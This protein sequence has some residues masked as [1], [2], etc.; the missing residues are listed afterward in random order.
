MWSR[1]ASSVPKGWLRLGGSSR[2]I[3]SRSSGLWG[4]TTGASSA[5]SVQA[6]ITMA[7]VI[8]AVLRRPRARRTGPRS[9]TGAAAVGV[10]RGTRSPAGAAT[11]APGP[12]RREPTRSAD[13]DPRVQDAIEEVDD[14]V[15]HDVDHRPQHGD[16][17]DRR[18]V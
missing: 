17:E 12:A 9:A 8:S 7:P 18:V 1:P 15:H 2:F 13:P 3:T 10:A 11:G 14:Q 4:A 16:A 6:P 5:T